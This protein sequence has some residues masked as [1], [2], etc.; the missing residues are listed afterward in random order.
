M[1]K[2]NLIQFIIRDNI[3]VIYPN[4]HIYHENCAQNQ[5]FE[6]IKKNF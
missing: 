4:K 3:F 1:F 2:L 5:N 6:P